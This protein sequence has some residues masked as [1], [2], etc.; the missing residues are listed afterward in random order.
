[1]TLTSKASSISFKSL[2]SLAILFIFLYKCGLTYYSMSF[3]LE[4]IFYLI[5]SSLLYFLYFYFF[6]LYYLSSSSIL[7]ISSIN[8]NSS[9]CACMYSVFCSWLFCL[10]SWILA[11]NSSFLVISSSILSLRRVFFFFFSFYTSIFFST[12]WLYS[13]ILF[14]SSVRIY[15]SFFSLNLKSS[16]CNIFFFIKCIASFCSASSFSNYCSTRCKH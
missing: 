2:L 7:A 16:T 9:S 13:K 11:S 1:M 5:Y 8:L 15:S 12:S 3:W 14:L 10:H 4:S 6:S